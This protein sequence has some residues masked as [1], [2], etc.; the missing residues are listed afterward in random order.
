MKFVLP[1]VRWW[2]GLL[3]IFSGLVKANDPLGLAYKMQE[4]FEVW[5]WHGLDGYTL[6]LSVVLNSVEI[7]AGVAL[8]TNWAFRYVG[9]LLLLLILLFTGLTGYTF[10]TGMPKNCGC[11]GDCLPIS[12][13]FSFGKDILL[14]GLISLLLC[15]YKTPSEATFSR[16]R[17]I[18][19]LLSL[20]FSVGLQWYALRYLPPVD[21]LPYK[22]GAS[23]PEGLKIPIDAIADSFVIEFTYRKNGKEVRFPASDFPA[24]FS[25][26]YEFVGRE[27]RLIRKGSNNEAPIKGFALQGISG[28]DSTDAILNTGPAI[29]IW[30]ASMRSFD[31]WKASFLALEKEARKKNLPVLL[32]TAQ[33]NEAA[34]RL[35]ALALTDLPIFSCDL[36]AIQTA[37]RVEPTIMLVDRGTIR[38]KRSIG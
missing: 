4:F 30:A 34:L 21:C 23:I 3:F 13:G 10:F 5:G 26:A 24:D 28:A 7:I 9:W 1:I 27:D 35:S 20:L 22:Q 37:A 17:L 25:A 14:T 32:I 6:G 38:K 11:F 33:P 19:V 31:R 18:P 16:K 12:A 8:L 2:V 29:W 15:C 36:K